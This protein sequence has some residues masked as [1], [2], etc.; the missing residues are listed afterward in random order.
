MIA[1]RIP[2]DVALKDA[3]LEELRWD[4]RVE[5]TDIGVEVDKGVVTLT[6]TVSSYT[7]KL[8]AAEAAHRVD[9]VLDVAN[10]ITVRLPGSPGH[11]DTEI[12]TAVRQALQWDVLV[13]DE[14]IQSTVTNGVVS[15]AGTVNTY[16]QRADAERAVRNLSGVR[17]IVN[18]LEVSHP[19]VNYVGPGAQS[20]LEDAIEAALERRAERAARRV[21]V[22]VKEGVVTLKG[23]V[24]TW[25][26]KE[27]IL[28]VVAHAPGIRSVRDEMAYGVARWRRRKSDE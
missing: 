4:G 22:S 8:A 18:H 24:A 6:G 2:K 10:D 14:D 5:E 3:V 12:A 23:H 21:R 7:K 26:D 1:P 17:E 9:G 15:L 20:D 25:G 13:P 19:D 16:L 28:G 27:A 11:S